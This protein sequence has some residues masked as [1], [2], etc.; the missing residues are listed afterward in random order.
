[1]IQKLLERLGCSVKVVENGREA[2]ETWKQGIYDVVFMDVQM[3]EMDGFE[4][5]RLIRQAESEAA[6]VR[7]PTYIVAVTAHALP[8]ERRKVPSRPEWIRTSQNR[9]AG[10]SGCS[11]RPT[12]TAC[13]RSTGGPPTGLKPLS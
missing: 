5:A 2:V 12:P 13:R 10:L 6:G 11:A 9:N 8:A 7:P 3:P 1:M 4:A